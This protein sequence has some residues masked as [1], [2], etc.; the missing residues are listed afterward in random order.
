M[1]SGSRVEGWRFGF[2]IR[3]WGLGFRVPG[4]LVVLCMFAR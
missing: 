2:R 1:I 4:L 3:V